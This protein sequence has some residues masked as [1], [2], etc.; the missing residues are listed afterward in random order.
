MGLQPAAG[1][2]IRERGVLHAVAAAAGAVADGVVAEPA[3]RGRRLRS[4]QPRQRVVAEVPGFRRVHAVG[5][6][7]DAVGGRG[8]VIHHCLIK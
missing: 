1:T 3:Q 8:S 7:G 4:D 5:D 6:V 2:G